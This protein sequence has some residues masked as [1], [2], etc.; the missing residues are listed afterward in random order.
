MV[1]ENPDVKIGINI[2]E[3][4]TTG[5]YRDPFVMYREYIQNSC[6]AI[7]EAA[8]KGLMEAEEGKIN[9]WLDDNEVTIEDNGIGISNTDFAPIL[10]SIGDSGKNADLN[11]GFRG[12]GHWCGLANCDKLTFTAKAAGEM[13]ESTMSCDAKMIREMMYEH[14]MKIKSFS[15]DDVLSQAIEF[16]TANVDNHD[17]HYFRVEMKGIAGDEELC[18]Q[19]KIKDYLSFVAPVGYATE[20]IY[21]DRIHNYAN[22]VG[23]KI[24]QYNIYIEGEQILKK[25]QLTF[26]T[27]SKGKD[28]IFDV[29]FKN[30][31]DNEG[32]LI[33]W[34]WYGVS[35]FKAQILS[36]C[37]MRGLR[38]RCKNI[39]LGGESALQHLFSETRGIYYFIGEVFSISNVLIPDSQRD[40]FEPCQARIQ[41]DNALRKFFHDELKDIYYKGSAINSAFTKI[42]KLKQQVEK[43]DNNF[44]KTDDNIDKLIGFKTELAKYK[45][46]IEQI[47][48]KV[49]KD[50]CSGNNV[51]YKIYKH[52]EEHN[53]SIDELENTIDNYEKNLENT[54]T[55]FKKT[56]ES[57]KIS[58]PTTDNSANRQNDENHDH[59]LD[60]GEG[61]KGSNNITKREKRPKGKKATDSNQSKL[62]PLNKIIEIINEVLDEATAHKLIQ[63]IKELD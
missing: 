52:V 2:L 57:E 24:S 23:Q 49:N 58:T 56:S 35:T 15:I 55:K 36:T 8:R 21:K 6:D 19:L 3:T 42:G 60:N 5:M 43:I 62:L 27:R 40:Y 28:K 53:C 46:D 11:R 41:F 22:D 59:E 12:I 38:L 45:H 9:I 47:H 31:R 44:V 33:A 25:Y 51:T 29:E 48:N 16:S 20:F 30:I 37:K 34:L 50:H 39:Q 61:S 26:D 7:D 1:L 54:Q 10:Y 17:L 32:N 63:R 4:L 14:R 18:D 13:V